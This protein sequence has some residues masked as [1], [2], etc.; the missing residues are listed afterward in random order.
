M[1][2]QFINATTLRK[3]VKADYDMGNYQGAT[4]MYRMYK[5]YGGTMSYDK[6][7]LAKPTKPK[8]RKKVTQYY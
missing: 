4:K 2:N 5:Q 7:T 1:R 8:K 6:I 3:W